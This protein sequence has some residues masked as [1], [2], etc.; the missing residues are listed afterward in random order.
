[1]YV[2]KRERRRHIDR[3]EKS[4]SHELQ[5]LSYVGTNPWPPRGRLLPQ[6]KP[7]ENK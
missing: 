4:V 6:S 3:K 7:E 1:M 5:A 2:S